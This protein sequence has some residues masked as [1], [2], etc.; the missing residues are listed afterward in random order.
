MT[1]QQMLEAFRAERDR[2]GVASGLDEHSVYRRAAPAEELFTSRHRSDCVDW[3]EA[4]A[5]MALQ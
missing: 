2:Y 5:M 4:R 3:I 1:P